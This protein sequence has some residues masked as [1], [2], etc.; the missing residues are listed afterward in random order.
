MPTRGGFTLEDVL[1]MYYIPKSCINVDT[2]N[3][4]FVVEEGAGANCPYFSF[5]I[6][7]SWQGGTV[8]TSR[9]GAVGGRTM[10]NGY[11]PH[12]EALLRYPY[13]FIKITD[14][15]GH[16]WIY[17]PEMFQY[18]GGDLEIKYRKYFS[19]GDTVSMGIKIT[20]YM[21]A[22]C[23]EDICVFQ[24]FPQIA[25]TS[26]S[27]QQYLALNKNS[28][29]NQ[30]RWMGYD[31]ALGVASAGIKTAGG[32]MTDNP[33]GLISGAQGMFGSIINYEK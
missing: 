16:E 24:T 22:E 5:T 14:R 28:L 30:Y 15:A 33:A 7:N 6:P 18:S 19:I 21:D 11:K 17:K 10:F 31:T 23:K 32:I 4:R 2:D 20:N 13:N 26:D 25:A 12:Q 1:A 9:L 8:Y 27:Y 3:P 29:Q